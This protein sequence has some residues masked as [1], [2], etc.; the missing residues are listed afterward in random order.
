MKTITKTSVQTLGIG[1]FTKQVSGIKADV[2]L[3]T[4]GDGYWSNEK[5]DVQVDALAIGFRNLMDYDENPKKWYEYGELRVF[6]T[7]QSWDTKEHG[8]IY[9]DS[10]FQRELRKWLTSLGLAGKD[11]DY[12]EQGMQGDNYVSFDVGQKFLKS[13]DIVT[14][15]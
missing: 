3:H 5:R 8:L 12:S 14:A 11:V 15:K 6:F 1:T 2:V 7:K 13:W 10:L 9:T 4:K